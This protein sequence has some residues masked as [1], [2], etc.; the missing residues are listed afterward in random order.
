VDDE[1]ALPEAF[2]MV[3]SQITEI[4]AVCSRFRSDSELSRLNRSAGSGAFELHP[5]LEEAI[6]AALRVAEMT[7][8]LV[9]PTI[10]RHVEDAGYTV[11]F[12]AIPKEGPPLELRI[13]HV[14]GWRA[15]DLDRGSHTACLPAGAA[16]DLGASGKAWAADRAADAV[17]SSL[18]V[19][20]L[21]DCGGDV[22]VRGRVPGQGWPVRVA[23]DVGAPDGQD[24]LVRDGGLAT[25]GT[26]SRRW[27][28]GGAEIHDIIDPRTGLPAETPWAMVTVAAA[29]CLEA[30]AASTAALIM[31]EEARP[32]LNACRLPAR[33]VRSNGR[34]ELAGGWCS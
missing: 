11:T 5:L 14:V 31:G 17:A 34:V 7:D 16:L 4:D 29:T 2:A 24:V 12:S 8:G 32:W 18:G 13:R 27:R 1:Q 15:V 21:V 23:S 6:A 22:S 28:R 25:S 9:D 30:N 33:L 3:R 20:V 10:G 26:T 19:G